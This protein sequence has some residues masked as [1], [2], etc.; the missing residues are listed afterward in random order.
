[1]N[2][3][4]SLINLSSSNGDLC[5][6]LALPLSVAL[7]SISIHGESTS[8]HS[9]FCLLILHQSFLN[10]SKST[11]SP[12]KSFMFVERESRL[13]SVNHESEDTS[14]TIEKNARMQCIVERHLQQKLIIPL[15]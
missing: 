11:E 14:R 6:Y 3:F 8:L 1:M 13:R 4:E 10:C 15:V 12:N 7:L 2:V 5:M 9:I